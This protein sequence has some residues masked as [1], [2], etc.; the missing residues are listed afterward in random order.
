MTSIEF[1]Y[2][3]CQDLRTAICLPKM[4]HFACSDW[5]ISFRCSFFLSVAITEPHACLSAPVQHIALPDV[6][7]PAPQHRVLLSE[8][9]WVGLTYENQGLNVKLLN[10]M[11]S[12]V[13]GET[14]ASS[15]SLTVYLLA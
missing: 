2:I 3:K 13:K 5:R 12:S 4:K 8:S 15:C 9:V 11:N 10:L 7:L 6:H 14:F 1:L